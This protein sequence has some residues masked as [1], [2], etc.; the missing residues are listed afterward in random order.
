M[1]C[2]KS[3]SESN[4]IEDLQFFWPIWKKAQLVTH[5]QT[6]DLEFGIRHS[7]VMHGQS[8]TILSPPPINMYYVMWMELN[9]ILLARSCVSHSARQ[10]YA[11]TVRYLTENNYFNIP[12]SCGLRTVP[13]WSRFQIHNPEQTK[14]HFPQEIVIEHNHDT[15]TDNAASA[16]RNACRLE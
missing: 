11:R 15:M 10:S 6:S 2:S 8:H 3:Y 4:H 13:L 9:G 5:T 16:M 7:L 14:K 12:K 1:W